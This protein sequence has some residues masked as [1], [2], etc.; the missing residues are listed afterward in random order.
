MGLENLILLSLITLFLPL[1]GFVLLIFFG[2]RMPREGDW[3]ATATVTAAFLASL[4]IMFAKLATPETVTAGWNW[5]TFGGIP[6]VGEVTVELG[7][8][9]DNLSAI[10]L[11][12]VT[13]ISMLVHFFSMGY[14]EGD[15]RYSRYFAYLGLFTFSMLGIV[16][17]HNLLMMYIFWELVGVSSYL[18]IGHWYEKKSASNAAIKAFVVNRVGDA[19]M[20]IG[21]MI[22]FVHFS[23]FSFDA[24]FSAVSAGNLPFE[25]Q[26][27]LTAVGVLIFCGAIGK[28][29]QFPLHVWLPDAM[30][31]P[32]PVSALIHAATMVAAGVFLVARLFPLFTADALLVIAYIGALTALIAATI[33]IT[34]YD[35][36]KVLAWSTISQLGYMILALGVGAYAA[37]FMHLVTHAAFKA[38][39]FLGSGAVIYA[40]HAAL[41]KQ[42]DHQTDA[43]DVRNMGGLRSRMPLTYWTFLIFTLAISGIPL[44]SGFLSKDEIL[45]GT[46]A[47]STLNGHY[48]LPLIAFAVAGMTAFYMFRLLILT[49]H[50][51][52]ADEERLTLVREVP[53][54][55]G[56]PLVILA[57]LSVFIFYSF[58]PFGASSGWLFQALER[59]ASV[60]PE[61]LAPATWPVLYEAIS[62]VHTLVMILSIVIAVGGLAFAWMVYEKRSVSADKMASAM[63]WLYH[64]SRKKW[65]FDEMYEA[66]FVNGTLGLTRIS[67]WFDMNIVDGIVN[68]A[69]SVTRSVSKI[70]GWI[71]NTFVDG[72]VNFLANFTGAIGMRLRKIQTG[73][74]QNYLV[75]AVFGFLII[76]ILILAI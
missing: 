59:P 14:L 52:P 45:A 30:E 65:Y 4:V 27:W 69:G 66:V 48:L 41:H 29:A 68:G 44:T 67:N 39:L 7:I 50:G 64:G 12:V 58:N 61:A 19:G 2:K 3:L 22:I 46:L 76:T 62:R 15:V 23:T 13:L 10:M 49:F 24:I 75:F 40:M 71:D 1:A 20:F 37:G 70:S 43:Q 38:G 25:S 5:A 32:T 33:A 6:G 21:I 60:V 18:L 36:K 26:A 34:Q 73:S 16:L 11:V 8:L 17:T 35:I 74:I 9:I 51:K 28:S 31:G 72:L 54:V 55:M 47:F 42:H 56:I 63:G 53:G 57:A